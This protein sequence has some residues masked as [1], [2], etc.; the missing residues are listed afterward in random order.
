MK[1]NDMIITKQV[2]D[3]GSIY[4]ETSEVDAAVKMLDEKFERKESV[5]IV[6]WF[7]GPVLIAVGIKL[8]VSSDGFELHESAKADG[9]FIFSITRVFRGAL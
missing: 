1:L 5:E 3:C 2:N 8:G 4:W 7:S 9:T 6:K